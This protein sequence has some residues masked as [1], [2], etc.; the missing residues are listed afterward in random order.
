MWIGDQ[1]TG[2]VVQGQNTRRREGEEKQKQQERKKRQ[3]QGRDGRARRGT[4][5]AAGERQ[6]GAAGAVGVVGWW[7]GAVSSGGGRV[8]GPGWRSFEALRWLARLEIAGVEPLGLALGFGRRATYS[9]LA[10]LADAGLL[11]RACD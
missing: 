3:R 10:R 1:R 7:W 4:R 2:K 11:V 8:R 6:A 9:H 5:R